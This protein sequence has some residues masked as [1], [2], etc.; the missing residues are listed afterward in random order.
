MWGMKKVEEVRVY[1]TGFLSFP[2]VSPPEGVIDTSTGPAP[3]N[4]LWEPPQQL[5]QPESL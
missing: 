1:L 3:H 2:P 4:R 5:T